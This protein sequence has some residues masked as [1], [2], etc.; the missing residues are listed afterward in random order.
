MST[1]DDAKQLS[2]YGFNVL[3]AEY[4]GRSPI[5]DWTKYQSTST[6]NMLA[7]WFKGKK[8]FNFWIATGRISGVVVIDFDN[9]GAEEWWREQLGDELID[10]TAKVKTRRGHH[11]YFR[12]PESWDEDRKI[13]SWSVHTDDLSFDVRCDGTG[14]IAPPSIHESGIQYEWVTPFDQVQDA[15]IELLDGSMRRSAPRGE[16]TSLSP[17]GAARSMLSHLLSHVPQSEGEGRNTWLANVAGHYA[18]TYHNMED[19]YYT[20]MRQANDMMPQPLSEPEFEKTVNSIWRSEQENN[21]H[22]AVDAAS[23]WLMDGGDVI[24]AQVQTKNSEGEKTL[25][26]EPYGNFNLIAKGVMVDE[27]GN[28]TYWLDVIVQH[29][30]GKKV[31]DTVLPAR[32]TGDDKAL[33]VWLQRLG[34]SVLPPM[35][36]YPKD[37]GP[38]VRLQRYL[39][40]QRPPEMRITPTLGWDEEV[41]GGAGGF[42]TH[43]G[44]ITDQAVLTTEQSGARANPA[45]KTGGVAPH[46][47]GFDHDADEARRV[48]EEVLTF[49]DETVTS[50]FGAWWAACLVKPQIEERSSLFP[51][52]ALEAP[53]ESGKTNG[54]FDMMVQLN[55][56]TRGESQSTKAA[57]RDMT[58][59]HRN[60]IVWIDDMDDPANLMEL[61]RAATSG[62]TITKMAED[63]VSVK[64]AKIVSPIVI[65]GEQL[66]MS[67]QKALIDR[68][69]VLNAPSP[70]KRTSRRDPSRPQWDDVLLLREEHPDGLSSVAGWLVQDALGVVPQVLEALRAGRTG[71]TGRTGDKHAVLRAGA[72]LLDWLVGHDGAAWGGAGEH[73]QRVEQWVQ[74][75]AESGIDSTDN[76]LTLRV[77]PWCLRQFDFADRPLARKYDDGVHTPVFIKEA[78][79]L[80]DEMEIWFSVPLLAEAWRRG[81]GGQFDKRTESEDALKGQADALD[82]PRGKQMKIAGG[83]GA[84]YYFRVIRGEQ[85]QR[86]MERAKG[87]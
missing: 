83:N 85:A 76:A 17:D 66:G 78:G 21:K 32:T 23:G 7:K 61:L 16:G 4:K 74:E 65:S 6:T 30:G 2:D 58:A 64:N 73:A 40:S 81:H 41:L 12:I 72:R 87:L 11:V 47:Y 60:G 34:A 18:R 63:H 13:P 80:L 50:V 38:G 3:P 36:M 59:A 55:G 14:V 31:V 69:I 43:D 5:V 48:L 26:M 82:S 29:P 79:D 42:V 52:V 25:E 8:P 49:H 19:L 86:V 44:V 27:D 67:T 45:L 37:G 62:G 56:N 71:G 46:E 35:G 33:R 54:F 57:L 77:I 9:D 15:P 53:S 39:E 10:A 75:Q 68:A 84:K 70:T 1:L 24:L 28:R 51:F 22:R 20:H